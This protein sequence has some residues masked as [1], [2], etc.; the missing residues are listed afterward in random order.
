[1]LARL[2]QLSLLHHLCV[3]A[4][5]F[6][7]LELR[8]SANKIFYLLVILLVAENLTHDLCLVPVGDHWLL[9]VL[10]LYNR[11][12]VVLAVDVVAVVLVLVEVTAI[13]LLMGYSSIDTF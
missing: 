13:H 6:F 1:M 12:S 4:L 5:V 7:I 10:L 2:L 3:N 11:L 9:E 8:T